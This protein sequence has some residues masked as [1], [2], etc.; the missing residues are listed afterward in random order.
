MSAGSLV[1]FMLYVT[2]LNGALQVDLCTSLINHAWP[3][4]A[5]LHPQIQCKAARWC[6]L[7]LILSL[8]RCVHLCR[9]W[10]TCSPPLR[11]PWER[12]TR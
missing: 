12:Q 5:Y 3:T 9:R 4:F 2:S 11:L 10:Q 8:R 6:M 1:S 7:C